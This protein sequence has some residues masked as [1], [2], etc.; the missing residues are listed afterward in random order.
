VRFVIGNIIDFDPNTKS[1]DILEEEQTRPKLL[2]PTTCHCR[3][4]VT[5][6]TRNSNATPEKEK[7]LSLSLHDLFDNDNDNDNDMPKS[8]R[9]SSSLRDLFECFEDSAVDL[10]ADSSFMPGRTH[11]REVEAP[12][13]GHPEEMPKSFRLSS[14]LR[15]LFECFED[16]A[17][18]LRADSSFMNKQNIPT[19]KKNKMNVLP[20]HLVSL[21]NAFS[22]MHNGIS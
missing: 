1:S 6:S 16:S 13:R 3:N 18:D 9:L 20:D 21:L 22:Q 8:L 5:A 14:S 19:E 15:D 17:D 12:K 7:R 2:H 10:R 4:G 11:Q